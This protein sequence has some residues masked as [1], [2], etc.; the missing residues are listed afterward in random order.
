MEKLKYTHGFTEQPADWIPMAE[1]IVKTYGFDPPA[2]MIADYTKDQIWG[3]WDLF[4]D[5]IDGEYHEDDYDD[6]YD[7]IAEFHV[8]H[9][10]IRQLTELIH[11]LEMYT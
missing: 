11:L 10:D 9:E 4:D 8:S 5:L 2:W 1:R 6:G 3:V 7:P